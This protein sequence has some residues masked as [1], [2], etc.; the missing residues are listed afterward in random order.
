[1]GKT[2]LLAHGSGDSRR[3]GITI[4]SAAVGKVPLEKGETMH[5]SQLVPC[6]SVSVRG[7]CSG[8]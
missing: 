3:Q 8:G 2:F 5:K 4:M 7:P 1:V 6:H